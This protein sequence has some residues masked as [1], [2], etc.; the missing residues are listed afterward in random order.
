MSGIVILETSNEI[1]HPVGYV[2]CLSIQ[3][4]NKR[5]MDVKDLLT[6][7]QFMPETRKIRFINNRLIY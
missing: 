4:P 6:C 1:D 3:L 7:H 5:R 2:H